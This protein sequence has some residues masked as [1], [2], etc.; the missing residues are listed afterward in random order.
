MQ[1]LQ[2]TSLS[3][4]ALQAGID[5][6]FPTNGEITPE[7]IGIRDKRLAAIRSLNVPDNELGTQVIEH[8]RLVNCAIGGGNNII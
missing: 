8:Y 1:A 2:P 4:D 6:A 7:N 3:N 5:E